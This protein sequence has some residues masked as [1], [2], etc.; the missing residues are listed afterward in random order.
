M[1]SCNLDKS[2]KVDITAPTG[3]TGSIGLRG[4]DGNSSRWKAN[5]QGI[6]PLTGQ[7]HINTI[8]NA[9]VINQFDSNTNDMLSWLQDIQK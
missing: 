7:F 3:P 2:V 8:G 5:T 9:I 6:T 1:F 4:Y